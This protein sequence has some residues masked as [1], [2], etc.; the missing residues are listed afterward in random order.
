MAKRSK[1]FKTISEFMDGKKTYTGIAFTAIGFLGAG[2]YI[3][4]ELD[5][6][7][8]VN[9]LLIFLGYVLAIYGRIKANK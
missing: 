9:G 6:T 7:N 1:M 3:G 8:A 4:G 2:K 5:F